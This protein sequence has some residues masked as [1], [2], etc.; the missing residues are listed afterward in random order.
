MNSH[1][2]IQTIGLTAGTLTTLS[3]IPQVVRAWRT[4]SVKDLSLGMLT[5][6]NVGVALWTVY[7][8][9]LGE[10]PIIITNIVTLGLALA[11]LGFKLTWR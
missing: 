1:D 2:L 4:R 6:F 11:L 7:G 10:L 9:A 3:F 8:F 5:T